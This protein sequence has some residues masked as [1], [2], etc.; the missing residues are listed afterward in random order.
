MS[1]G[2]TDRGDGLLDRQT[3]GED[4]VRMVATQLTEPQTA[5]WIATEAG[6]SHE[7]TK[8]SLERL[9][10]DG[11]LRQRDDGPHTTYYPDYRLQTIREATRLRDESDSV[12]TLTDRLDELKETIDTWRAEFGVE[13]P[14]ELRATI[15]ADAGAED[16]RRAVAREWDHLERRIR[17][18]QFA[19]REWEFLAPVDDEHPTSV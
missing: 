5:N 7:P 12:E 16:S 17:I 6:W 3:T 11:V 10:E 18:V 13:S 2:A 9:V 19:I 4:R 15:G 14:N 1:D 8:R